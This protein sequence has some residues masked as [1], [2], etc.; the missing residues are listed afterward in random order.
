[1]ISIIVGIVFFIFGFAIGGTFM[2]N[3]R[4]GEIENGYLNFNDKLYTVKEMDIK[5]E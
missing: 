5:G 3:S 1:M 4:R 2:I